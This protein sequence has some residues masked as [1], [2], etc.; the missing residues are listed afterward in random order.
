MEITFGSKDDVTTSKQTSKPTL[1]KLEVGNSEI[2][3]KENEE[4]EQTPRI[5]LDNVKVNEILELCIKDLKFPRNIDGKKLILVKDFDDKTK[6]ITF[7]E[8][9]GNLQKILKIKETSLD[10]FFSWYFVNNFRKY[11]MELYSAL[12]ES[13]PIYTMDEIDSLRIRIDFA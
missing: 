11:C 12:P 7:S 4:K 6:I 13:L 9:I 8:P 10:E 2:L 5:A 1:K 3:K